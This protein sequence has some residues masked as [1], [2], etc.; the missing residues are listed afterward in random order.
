MRIRNE[1]FLYAGKIKETTNGCWRSTRGKARKALQIVA[2]RRF[3][4]N[5][6]IDE[7][8]RAA[9]NGQDKAKRKTDEEEAALRV[10][11]SFRDGQNTQP[12]CIIS[13]TSF[14]GSALTL[15]VPVNG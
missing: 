8:S 6:Q 9:P 13:I 1:T 5:V 2:Q 4:R 12:F 14:S 3:A 7:Q 11:R 15:L 10:C